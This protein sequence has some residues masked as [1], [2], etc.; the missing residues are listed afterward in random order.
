MYVLNCENYLSVYGPSG[1]Q[2]YRL[3]TQRPLPILANRVGEV[4]PIEHLH[5]IP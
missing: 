2:N 1:A 5:S 3:T 4:E